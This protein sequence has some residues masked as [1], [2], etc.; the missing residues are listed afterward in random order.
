MRD[1]GHWAS[2]AEEG[3]ERTPLNHKC[4]AGVLS[5]DARVWMRLLATKHRWSKEAGLPGPL[6]AKG[7]HD[8]M[9]SVVTNP[10]A[11]SRT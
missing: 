1:M 9:R 5:E 2:R 6:I 4:R 10:F 3:T 11:L 8:G 7:L